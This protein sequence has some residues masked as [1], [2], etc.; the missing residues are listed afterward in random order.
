[1]HIKVYISYIDCCSCS[2]GPCG[3]LKACSLIWPEQKY[4]QW[5]IQHV[6]ND[7]ANS[8]LME[9]FLILSWQIL[10]LISHFQ[11][12]QTEIAINQCLSFCI[13]IDAKDWNK[14]KPLPCLSEQTQ[15]SH[16]SIDIAYSEYFNQHCINTVDMI[17]M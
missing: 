1:M 2:F 13:H 7:I 9:Q 14:P 8:H 4:K 17:L 11:Y 3:V 10:T 6:M 16:H 15:F 12:M 5:P